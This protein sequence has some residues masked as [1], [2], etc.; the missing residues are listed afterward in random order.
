MVVKGEECVIV[1]VLGG[2]KQRGLVVVME[3]VDGWPAE[4]A[5]GG[6]DQLEKC[7]M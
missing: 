6:R 1:V 4:V 7:V 3:G 2:V 5:E